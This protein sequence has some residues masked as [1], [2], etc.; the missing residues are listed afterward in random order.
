LRRYVIRFTVA[1]VVLMLV[2]GIATELLK[3][4]AAGGLTI[5]IALGASFFAAAAFAK[6][7][8]RA[9]TTEEKSTFAWWSLVSSWLTSLL[10]T[11][12]VVATSFSASEIQGLKRALNSPAILG[13]GLAF[14][15]VVSAVLYFA[16]RWAFGWYA[17]LAVSR[18]T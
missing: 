3:I 10:L 5:A 1:S 18:R 4:K 13:L 2:L 15:V 17:T 12:A 11:V 9:P 16:I 8:S 14:L 7:Q 6:D